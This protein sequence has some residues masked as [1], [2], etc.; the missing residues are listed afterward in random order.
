[1]QRAMGEALLT[2]KLVGDRLEL[3]ARGVH[4]MLRVA[5][6]IADLR[7]HETVGAEEIYAAI[8]KVE[9]IVNEE[10]IARL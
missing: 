10:S 1:M 2:H 4:R 6:T 9:G 8:E 7:Q 5:R 3:T